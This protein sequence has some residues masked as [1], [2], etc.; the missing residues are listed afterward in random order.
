MPLS[1]SPSGS[2]NLSSPPPIG[3]GTPNTIAAT[4]LAATTATL[5]RTS[6]SP[7]LS[8]GTGSDASFDL[9][10][11]RNAG[12]GAWEVVGSNCPGLL[13]NPSGTGTGLIY[14]GST[15]TPLTQDSSGVLALRN[16]LTGQALLISRTFTDASNKSQLK[17][18]PAA[19][20]IA[21][22]ADEAGT[23]VGTLLSYTF[24]LN[25]GT[26]LTLT[27]TQVSVGPNLFSIG[28]AG[29]SAAG[30]GGTDLTLAPFGGTTI[31]FAGAFRLK[32]YTV[33]TLPSGVQGDTAF[34]TDALLP[35]F[36]VTVAGMGAV[37]TKVFYDGTNWVAQ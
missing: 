14:I 35:S 17:I 37:V 11:T 36:L 19:S 29:I 6:G 2:T 13:L 8:L 24:A 26:V 30:S 33:A 20:T 28:N 15:G 9:T 25:S 27:A 10:F 32:G 18:A 12:T 16:G 21:F 23:G 7:A 4:T 5:R 34:V 31:I 22:L 1:T 3:D